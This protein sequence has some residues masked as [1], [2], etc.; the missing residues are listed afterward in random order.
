MAKLLKILSINAA[1]VAFLLLAPA[2]FFQIYKHIR[3]SSLPPPPSQDLKNNPAYPDQKDQDIAVRMSKDQEQGSL[4]R[5]FIGW[6]RKPFSGNYKN[7]EPPYNTRLSVNNSIDES[8]WFFGGSTM[9]GSGAI[10]SETIPSWYARH[11]GERVLNLGETA[12]VSRQ[13]LNQLVNLLGDSRTP[14][15]VIFY[16]G[17]NDILHGCRIEN[18]LVPA[19]LQEKSISKAL[20][21]DAFDYINASFTPTKNYLLAPYK[22]LAAKLGLKVSKPRGYGGMDC[23]TDKAKAAKVAAHLVNN[24][25]S[26]YAIT[27][28]RGV[29]F[30]AILQPQVFSSIIEKDYLH[31]GDNYLQAE[32]MAVYPLI[33]EK[34]EES[35]KSHPGFCS[36]VVDGSSWLDSKPAVYIDFCHLTGKGNQIIAD[37]ISEI[38]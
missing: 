29:D 7:V 28:Q 6:R 24:W 22:A 11:T 4:Y 38:F 36:H 20:E 1:V 32:Y 18:K 15:G 34:M 26:A 14:K 8:V 2:V 3:L 25:F 9:W 10:D 35:C 5:S 13:S 33:K 19:H 31:P 23:S 37:R 21:A 17:V 16:D 12:W 30:I 27:K